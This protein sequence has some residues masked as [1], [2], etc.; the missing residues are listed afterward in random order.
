MKV[1]PCSVPNEIHPRDTCTGR[2][3][4]I[5]QPSVFSEMLKM[6]Q[7]LYNLIQKKGIKK[8]EKLGFPAVANQ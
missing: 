7:I 1:V 8:A 6:N 3:E 2:L 4:C 5:V